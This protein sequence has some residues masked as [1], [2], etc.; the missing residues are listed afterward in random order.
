MLIVRMPLVITCVIASQVRFAI[1]GSIVLLENR[2]ANQRSVFDFILLIELDQEMRKTK[3]FHK[4]RRG[5]CWHQWMFIISL[6]W[7]LRLFL[8][9]IYSIHNHL[10]QYRFRVVHSVT[11]N[12]SSSLT[13][14]NLVGSY[15]CGCFFKGLGYNTE[16]KTCIN[17]ITDY[18]GQGIP[19]QFNNWIE[20]SDLPVGYTGKVSILK[21][22][23]MMIQIFVTSRVKSVKLK[24]DRTKPLINA[25]AKTDISELT[26]VV[27]LTLM[28]ALMVLFVQLNIIVKILLVWL[29]H[30]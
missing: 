9:W 26:G 25:N 10:Y 13:H 2:A 23:T 1:T 15:E 11:D 7:A 24:W 12:R 5:V 8:R 30:F 6:W 28:N 20:I 22:K 14:P 18:C 16:T 27:A 4:H 3:R 17:T 29:I 19:G 21:I